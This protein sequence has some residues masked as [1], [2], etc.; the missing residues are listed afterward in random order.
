MLSADMFDRIDCRLRQ[1]TYKYDESF[2]GLDLIMCGDH[3]QLPPVPASEVY[4]RTWDNNQ[5]LSFEVKS[6]HLSYFPLRQMVRQKDVGFSAV[7]TKIGDCRALEP[8]EVRLT[9]S[10]F[11]TAEH[12]LIEASGA[13]SLFY[14]NK[15]VIFFN[16][17]ISLKG[18][19]DV[20]EAPASNSY[21]KYKLDE[22]SAM[23]RNMVASMSHTEMGNLTDTIMLA[24]VTLDKK[25]GVS[26]KRKQFLDV[27]PSAVTVH[28]SPSATYH[29]DFYE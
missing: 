29:E 3:R 7:L 24:R 14:T 15:D 16:A 13:V 18:V 4:K 25:P 5:V 22:D 12:V 17:Q 11:V 21:L 6:H 8:K 28:K 9:G 10:R 19:M 23:A 20:H 26:C 27:K 2:G 1:I